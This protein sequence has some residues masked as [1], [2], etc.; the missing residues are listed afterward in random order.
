MRRRPSSSMLS[1]SGADLIMLALIVLVV[2][3]AICFFWPDPKCPQCGSG[4]T[5]PAS[6][7]MFHHCL[8]C[9]LEWDEANRDRY[10]G[11]IRGGL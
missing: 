8:S 11:I 7:P 5:L 6:V 2:F 1:R 4:K 10:V 3:V 9:R